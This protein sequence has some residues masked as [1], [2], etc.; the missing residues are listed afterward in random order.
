LTDAY[1]RE[2]RA[3]LAGVLAHSQ[4]DDTLAADAQ[5]FALR[6]YI[7]CLEKGLLM[8]PLRDIFA[9]KYI[10]ETVDIFESLTCEDVE[11][12]EGGPT[13]N[14]WAHDV[15]NQYFQTVGNHPTI[16]AAREKYRRIKDRLEREPGHGHPYKRDLTPLSI[17]YDAML[18]LTKRRRSVRWYLPKPVPREIIDRAI[19]IAA[20]SP[21][22]CNRQPFEFRVYDDPK[23]V[24]KIAEIPIGIAGFYK[25]LP[26]IAVLIGHLEAFTFERDR[27]IIYIDSALAAMSFQLALEVE[28][29][30]SCCLN[31]PEIPKLERRIAKILNLKP[32]ER[33][34]M[35]ISFGYP[36]PEGLVAFSHKKSVDEIRSYN[37][38]N[39]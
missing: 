15:L 4:T 27:H 34:V 10:M 5:R 11:C 14:I 35:L 8:R 37:R 2:Q 17:T 22:A 39:E 38:T 18:S 30:G 9:L 23:L 1:K 33:P 16:D 20:Y 28:G 3:V 32:F 7:H 21:S 6:R 12:C 36:D 13:L 29:I 31:W 25:Q 24:R 26:C 19:Q